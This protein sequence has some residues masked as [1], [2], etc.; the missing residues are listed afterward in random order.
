MAMITPL[1][2]M[3]L[4]LLA[5]FD[6][7]SGERSEIERLFDQLH[8]HEQEEARSL[9]E[10][11]QAATTSPDAGVRY[12]M[13]LVLEDERR[14]HR[15]TQAMADEVH[16]SLQWLDGDPPLP[17]I[18]ATGADQNQLLAQTRRFLA[19]ETDGQRKL[20][21]L[22]KQVKSLHS[23]LLELIVELMEADT[24]K[25]I[26]VLKYIEHQLEVRA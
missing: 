7:D 8:A 3:L 4:G 15:M 1:P 20:E 21:E 14:H 11:E 9:V 18:T 10:Y 5:D 26:Q 6:A 2:P 24:K 12:L 19:V 16:K 17:P 22:R 23:G 13:G 25:H